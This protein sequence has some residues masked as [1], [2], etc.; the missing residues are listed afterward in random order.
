MLTLRANLLLLFS[1]VAMPALAPFSLAVAGG[2]CIVETEIVDG[3]KFKADIC[4]PDPNS[5]PDF[6]M[7]FELEFHLDPE[8]PGS[9]LNLTVPCVG[10]SVE[11]LDATAIADVESRLPDPL[12]QSIDP[13]LPLRVTIEP[14]VACG[15]EFED[16]YDAEFDADNLVWNA[17]SPYRLMKA[18]I[19]GSYRDITAEVTPGSVRARGCGGTFSEFV[20]VV[21]QVQDYASESVAAFADLGITLANGAIGPTAI[22]TLGNDSSVSQAAFAAGNYAEAIAR[23]DDMDE[24]CGTLGGPALP[25]RWRSARDL[26]NLEGEVVSRSGH[27]KFLL[28]RLNGDP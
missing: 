5:G 25:N 10:F 11:I 6:E 3:R 28:G 22:T 2:P 16:D 21:D 14:P 1:L 18:P 17:Q 26:E 13:A 12:N 9:L 15:L 24:H 8:N 7:D 19:G 27:L 4:L 23:L 20:L